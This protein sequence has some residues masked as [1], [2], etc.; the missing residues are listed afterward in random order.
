MKKLTSILALITF[1]SVNAQQATSAFS[2][3]KYYDYQK[4]AA[5]QNDSLILFSPLRNL[6]QIINTQEKWDS[7][8]EWKWVRDGIWTGTALGASVVGYSLIINKDDITEAKL[9]EILAKEDDINFLDKWIAG[10]D[11]KAALRQSN[12][13]FG[14]LLWR[15]WF[16]FLTM[17]STITPGN[18]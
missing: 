12:I 8:Y 3:P 14:Y 18:I 11:S 4:M 1:I 9:Q 15:P 16:F 7:P 6:S 13:V 10:N 2:T 5:V 17:T